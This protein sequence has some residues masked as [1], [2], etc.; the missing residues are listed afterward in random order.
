MLELIV[1]IAVAT[2]LTGLLMPA[3]RHVQENAH[4]IICM[5][6]LQ[7]MGQAMFLY[8]A[9]YNDRLPYSR[10][11]HVENSPADLMAAREGGDWDGIG[12]LYSGNFCP[13]PECFYCPSHHGNHNYERYAEQWVNPVPSWTLY[14]NYHYA[15]DVDWTDFGKRRLLDDGTLPLISDGLRTASDF[16]HGTGLNV[17]RA[18]GSV[19]WADDNNGILQ[20]LP[21]S[22]TDSLPPDYSQL[23]DKVAAPH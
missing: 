18:D 7:Q 4:R 5:S 16:N 20:S 15:G 21:A 9:T 13:A 3:M 2:L 19:R 14:T 11:L 12:L 6:H 8:S 22:E 23:W 10:V 1:V 17:L